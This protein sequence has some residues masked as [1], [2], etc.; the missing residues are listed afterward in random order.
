MLDSNESP[1]AVMPW[2]PRFRLHLGP[3]FDSYKSYCSRLLT[4]DKFLWKGSRLKGRSHE[5]FYSED[6]EGD[7]TFVYCLK[8]FPE[9]TDAGHLL[10][11]ANE[12]GRVDIRSTRSRR[13]RNGVGGGCPPEME[14]SFTAHKNAIF[15][16]AWIPGSCGSRLVTVSGDATARLWDLNRLAGGGGRAGS[17]N[18]EQQPVAV[19][20]GFGRSVKCAEF[21]PQDPNVFAAGSRENSIFLWD[22]RCSG[23][24]S[25]EK[26]VNA[27]RGAHCV[28]ATPGKLLRRN[29]TGSSANRRRTTGVAAET[30]NSARG[31]V[32]ALQFGPLHSETLVSCSDLD[33]V[34]KVWDLRMSYDRFSGLPRAR[35]CFP[36]PGTSALTGFSS[37]AIDS[38]GRDRVFAACKD[39]HVYEFRIDDADYLTSWDETVRESGRHHHHGSAPRA[40]FSGYVNESKYFIRI[41]V[42][43][44][45]NYLLSGS[46]DGKAYAW[47]VDAPCTSGGDLDA[48]AKVAF[49]CRRPPVAALEGHENDV[50]CVDFCRSPNETL[51]FATCSDDFSCMLWRFRSDVVEEDEENDETGRG[52]SGVSVWNPSVTSYYKE[53][54][55]AVPS[56]CRGKGRSHPDGDDV[57]ASGASL[58]KKGFFLG[59]DDNDENSS[60]LSN[61]RNSSSTVA[62]VGSDPE[63]EGELGSSPP[64]KACRWLGPVVRDWP[65]VEPFPAA[66]TTTAAQEMEQPRWTLSV[67][68]GSPRKRLYRLES[69][70]K[71]SIGR[72]RTTRTSVGEQEAAPSPTTN[73]PN[74]VVDGRSPISTLVEAAGPSSS[75]QTRRC[76]NASRKLNWLTAFG[77]QKRF[78]LGRSSSKARDGGLT[79]HPTP[80]ASGKL[81]NKRKLPENAGSPVLPPKRSRRR[82]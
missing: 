70:K 38:A 46:S 4:R 15:D 67:T 19:F 16:V 53:I 27:I 33:G 41:A 60:L 66:A 10:A 48:D 9:A 13:R 2:T 51:M 29:S 6:L 25:K 56:D 22:V 68:L 20:S 14:C 30:P 3:A 12:D 80:K 1:F 72:G 55:R 62:T 69:P 17:G 74:F 57:K 58:A 43:P 40:V 79:T 54:K 50:T 65:K 73:L 47:S 7:A 59:G 21:K 52:R 37:L 49:P 8:F 42:S 81:R 75:P 61:S 39:H 34:V 26:P 36:Y 35:S 24:S 23:P 71:L 18:E 44:D 78:R 32:T 31:S 11:V 77:E 28:P 76:S 82:L 5:R 63:D 45:D 64:K